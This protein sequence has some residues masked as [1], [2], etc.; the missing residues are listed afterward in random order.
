MEGLEWLVVPAAVAAFIAIAYVVNK[1]QKAA[2]NAYTSSIPDSEIRRPFEQSGWRYEDIE[3]APIDQHVERARQE[4]GVNT[5]DRHTR[6]VRSY[7][8]F[9]IVSDYWMR[10]GGGEAVSQGYRASWVEYGHRLGAGHGL[11]PAYRVSKTLTLLSGGAPPTLFHLVEKSLPRKTAWG[12]G[13]QNRRFREFQ[14]AYPLA[15]LTGDPTIDAR[16]DIYSPNPQGVQRM[17]GQAAFAAALQALPFVQL[18]VCPDRV[19][20][21]DPAQLCLER[22]LGGT[23]GMAQAVGAAWNAGAQHNM[24]EAASLEDQVSDLLVLAA[25]SRH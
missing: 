19:I 25:G 18:V 24:Q 6:M 9:R 12:S 21:D 1:S 16:F 17:L 13:L 8:G 4:M 22:R 23:Q 10:R 15:V 7:Q 2:L 20:F 5:L 11:R 14:P 3:A